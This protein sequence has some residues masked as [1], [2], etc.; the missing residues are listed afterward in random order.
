MPGHRPEPP[1]SPQ[2]RRLLLRI[3]ALTAG[4]GALASTACAAPAP[5]VRRLACD[6][7]EALW[8]SFVNGFLQPDGRV[9]DPDTEARVS[10]SEGQAYALFFALVAND[11]PRFDLLLHWT[12]QNL[13]G[14]D[15]AAR[16]PAWQWGRQRDGRWGVLDPNAASDADLWLAWTLIEA[17]RLWNAPALA[18]DG[19]AL[20]ARI[21][22]EEVVD[23]PGLGTM[24]LPGPQGFVSEDRLQWRFNPSYAPLHLLRGLA[25][26]DPGGPWTVLAEQSVRTLP[27]MAPQGL[28]PDWAT[29]SVQLTSPLRGRWIAD[30]Q[31]GDTGSY[32][33]IRC[34]LWAGVAPVDDPLRPALLHGLSGVQRHTRA[35]TLPERFATRAAAGADPATVARGAAPPGFAAALQPYLAALGDCAGTLHLAERLA[36]TC[37]SGTRLRYYDHALALF[38]AGWL[39]QRWHSDRHGRLQRAPTSSTFRCP[40]P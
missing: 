25:S 40:P 14:G 33:A 5:P 3:G 24:L 17:A 16:L 32:D 12:R 8:A 31:Q 28:A 37:A 36:A 23:V 13:C 11:R 2:R 22:A 18:V 20:L 26:A 29:W 6:D 4:A 30:T 35:A 10:T 27:G 7:F 19:R 21:R 1:H 38:S 9:L 15:L 39:Q 34:Y